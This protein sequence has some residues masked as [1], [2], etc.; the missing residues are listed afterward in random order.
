[1]TAPVWQMENKHVPLF[2]I[3][4]AIIIKLRG[5]QFCKGFSFF[6]NIYDTKISYSVL[7]YLNRLLVT[8]IFE[9]ISNDHA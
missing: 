6:F 5:E 2:L 1:M 9:P 8:Y 4:T 7:I 3:L